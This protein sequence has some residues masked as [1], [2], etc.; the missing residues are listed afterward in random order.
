MNKN[1]KVR[2]QRNDHPRDYYKHLIVQILDVKFPGISS[3][4][5]VIG[6]VCWQ[7]D[8]TH[9]WYGMRLSAECEISN[10]HQLT[11]MAK[12]G[13]RI[14]GSRSSINDSPEDVLKVLQA[15]EYKHVF[16]MYIPLSDRGKNVYNVIQNNSL[17]TRIVATDELSALKTAKKLKLPGVIRLEIEHENLQLDAGDISIEMLEKAPI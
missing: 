15:E 1:V 17:W 9:G 3:S 11:K 6:I 8:S 2:I 10:I 13:E 12:I 7:G 16:G 4:L 14:K 5:E